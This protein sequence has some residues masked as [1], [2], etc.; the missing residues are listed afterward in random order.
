[1]QWFCTDFGIGDI[2]RDGNVDGF[3]EHVACSQCIVDLLLGT[4]G[5]CGPARLQWRGR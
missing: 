4:S 5:G 3:S 2:C 1:L